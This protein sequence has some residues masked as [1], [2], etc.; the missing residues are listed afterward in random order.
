M[1]ASTIF[2]PQNIPKPEPHW[3]DS[4]HSWDL[5][6]GLGCH[7]LAETGK[8]DKKRQI[9]KGRYGVWPQKGGLCV[10]LKC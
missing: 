8:S 4:Q 3:E 10:P 9:W 2:L 6:T 5:P 7:F 1:V